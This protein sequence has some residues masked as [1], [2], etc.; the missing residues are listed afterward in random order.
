MRNT[1]WELGIG[2]KDK[3]KDFSYQV[4]FNISD[5]KNKVLKNGGTPI[6]NGATIQ[7]EGYALDSYYGYQ[8]DGLFQTA[9]EVKNAP[10]Q[11]GNTAAGDIRY[12]DI[13]GPNG[14][15]D[16]KIDSYDRTILG[17]YFPRYEYS[18]NLAAQYKGFD[19]TGF[20]QGVGKKDNYLSGTGS[21]PFYSANFQGSMY[22]HQKDFWTPENTGAAYPRLTAN[23]IA[24]NYVTSSYWVRSASYLRIK[25]LVLGYTVPKAISG[26]IKIKSARIYLSGQNL[27]TW[28]NFFPGFD[29]EQRDTGGE[30]YPIMKTYTVGI[31]IN[32]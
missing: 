8:A 19:V 5:V 13:S 27:F 22:E 12:R 31:N 32:L 7:Q 16:N 2:W 9:E 21:Q 3:I 18:F 10:F 6:I 20:F 14:V 4:Q 28:N 11:F 25:N 17:N 23:S 24:N 26:K 30:F 29:P 15:P 1:G